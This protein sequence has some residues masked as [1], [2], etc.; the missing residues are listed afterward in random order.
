M[1]TRL[2]LAV[3]VVGVLTLPAG[4]APPRKAPAVD[5]YGDP[6][7]AGA[8]A[9]LG[10]VS[11]SDEDGGKVAYSADGK[12]VYDI[13]Y[14]PDGKTLGSTA[15]DRTLRLWRPADGTAVR[16]LPLGKVTR[17]ISLDGTLLA[18][19]G[20]VEPRRPT[21]Y[22][23][24][25]EKILEVRDTLTGKLRQQL[26]HGGNV[27]RAA[28]A[29]DGGTLAVSTEEADVYLWDTV[30]GK[31]LRR[32]AAP[33]QWSLAFSP[34]GKTVATGDDDCTVR[35]WEAASGR[36]LRRLGTALDRSRFEG[37]V[38]AGT[39]SIAF[40][41]D[42]K[43]VA[44]AVT[45]QNTIF[46][47][48]AASGKELCQCKGHPSGHNPGW[49]Y[50][51]AFSPDGK[52]L[53]SGSEDRTVRLWEIATGKERSRLEG[54]RGAVYTL[55]VSPNGTRLASGSEDCTILVWDLSAAGK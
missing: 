7:P 29:P 25:R 15:A 19:S 5:L 12:A 45:W 21:N 8:V 23:P 55:A 11:L 44:A 34:E 40:A 2:Q 18:I 17:A 32:W 47:W 49:V 33:A 30:T 36:L 24:Q 6:L 9:R 4:G 48:N 50:A 35:L 51:L 38:I 43:T 41:P 46:V 3:V 16:T 20:L 13:R 27:V 42:G 37:L 14:L 22:L 31:L 26:T 52:T 28:W 1:K 39:T 10:T 53:F 54:H